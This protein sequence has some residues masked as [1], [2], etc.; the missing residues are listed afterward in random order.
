MTDSEPNL[1]DQIKAA[2]RDKYLAEAAKA[3]AEKKQIDFELSQSKKFFNIK[4]IWSVIIGVGFLGFFIS[5]ALVPI[6]QR[7]NIL[8]GIQLA[9]Q[10]DSLR[11]GNKALKSNYIA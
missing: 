4:T 5:Y 6:A 11:L 3:I 10:S 2:E 9:K 8:L 1:N 7:D